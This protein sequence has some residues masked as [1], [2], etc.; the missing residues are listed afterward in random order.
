MRVSCIE[1]N[2]CGFFVTNFCRENDNDDTICQHCLKMRIPCSRLQKYASTWPKDVE[3]TADPGR[4]E[5][6]KK[7][8]RTSIS[9]SNNEGERSSSI[10]STANHSGIPNGH[11]SKKRKSS[12]EPSSQESKK[13]NRTATS[14]GASLSREHVDTVRANQYMSGQS[15]GPHSAPLHIGSDGRPP[16]FPTIENGMVPSNAY[17]DPEESRQRHIIELRRNNFGP[18]TGYPDAS[19]Q[20]YP[21][22]SPSVSVA[23]GNG[24]IVPYHPPPPSAPSVHSYQSK[25]DSKGSGSHH[26]RSS[27]PQTMAVTSPS[28]PVAMYRMLEPNSMSSHLPP[29]DL[30]DVLVK[31]Y[32]THFYSQTYAFLHKPSFIRTLNQ[33]PPILLFSICAVAARFTKECTPQAAEVWAD[34]TR[35]L[36]MQNYDTYTLEVVQ[37]MVHMGIHDFGTNNGHKAWIFAGMA[38]RMGSAM[39]MNL[40]KHKKDMST[41][42]KEVTRRTYWSYYLMDV[43]LS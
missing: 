1:M 15:P 35:Q 39:N 30:L 22:S 5:E 38:V 37:S 19:P 29:P 3:D 7:R 16:P 17:E 13:A 42:N 8:S 41:I 32:F 14:R 26:E 34:C 28:A 18:P 36:I 40:E 2:I 4:D 11:G 20:S 24:V 23:S 10:G 6:K 25:S 27:T 12:M 33:Q 43:S 21:P 9:K 31:A